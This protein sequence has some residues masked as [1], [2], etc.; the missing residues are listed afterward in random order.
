VYNNTPKQHYNANDTI[1]GSVMWGAASTVGDVVFLCKVPHGAK[2]VDFSE[3]HSTG[4][5]GAG[6][7]FGFDK[8]V[9]AGGGGNA[10][11]LISGGAQAQ[12]NSWN[13]AGGPLTIS[14][15][16]LDPVRYATLIAKLE[17]GTTT[18]STFIEQ[19]MLTY[20]TDGPDYR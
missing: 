13:F 12:R 11:I 14:L 2:I 1:S 3:R 17:S 4:A 8:G 15:S 16:D 18:T 7:S 6:L 10:S 19:F 5:T 20:R 9:V